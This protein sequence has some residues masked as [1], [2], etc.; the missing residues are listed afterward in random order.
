MAYLDWLETPPE[1]EKRF[2]VG[3]CGW[4]KTVRPSELYLWPLLLQTLTLLS[5][6]QPEQNKQ[7][8]STM[9]TH[10]HDLLHLQHSAGASWGWADTSR[11]IRQ[12]KHFLFE[13]VC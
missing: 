13:V 2:L 7:V 11:T 6:S 1:E 8:G 5:A 4:L 3:A 10:R 12:P 9:P